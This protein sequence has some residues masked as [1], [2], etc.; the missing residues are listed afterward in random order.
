MKHLKKMTVTL[1]LLCTFLF[2]G[3]QGSESVTVQD[4]VQNPV[5]VKN[6]D[7]AN[8]DE[9]EDIPDYSGSPYITVNNNEPNFSA[10]ERSQGIYESYADLDSLGRCGTAE[11]CIGTELMPT[12]DRESISEVKPTG[13]INHEYDD[14]DGGWLYNRCHLIGYQLTAEN[15]NEK[16]LI[17]GTRY[18]NVEGMLPFENEVAEYIRET[19]NEVMYRVTPVF[20]DDNLVASGVWMEAESIENDDISFSVYVYN[21]QP[22]IVIDY[23]TGEN[24]DSGNKDISFIEEDDNSGNSSV[25]DRNSAVDENQEETY[26]LNNKT[27]KF[28]KPDCSSVDDI[29]NNNKEEFTGTRDELLNQGYSPCGKCKP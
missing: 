26:I 1:M 7:A 4:T 6:T 3:C 27:M 23:E 11:A 2:T 5:Q 10:E 24:W 19:D 20:E 22:G 17:T 15:A 16:N 28:H 12:E 29:S 9:L 21:V 18:M 25:S 14:V 8:V 13:W